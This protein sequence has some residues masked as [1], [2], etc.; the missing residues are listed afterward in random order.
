ME[1]DMGFFDETS[2]GVLISR[3][4][5]DPTFVFETYDEK[6]NT[7]VQFLAQVIVGLL[8]A[9]II[10]WRV[11]IV[12]IGV[13]P[14]CVFIYVFGEWLVDRLWKSFRDASTKTGTQA[15]EVITSFRTVKSFDNE[16]YEAEQ[17]AKNLDDVH[18]VVARAST[19]H[20][21]KN[22]AAYFF[23]FA[24]I[25]P[26]IY[27]SSYSVYLRPHLGMEIGDVITLSVCL[28][29]LL[30][31]FAMCLSVVDDM[32]KAGYSAR[33][34]LMLLEKKPERDR[35]AGEEIGSVRGKIEFCD[36]SF[37][38]K[39]RD[40]YAVEHLSFTINAGETVALV[41]ESGCGKSTTLQLLQKLYEVES[42]CIKI[43]DVDIK[44]LSD[45]SLRSQI[46][47]VPQGPVLFSMSVLDNIRFGKPDA[48]E[49]ST[50]SAARVGNAHEFIMELPE[51]YETNVVQTSLSG[52]QKQRICI[53][54]AILCDTPI[55][56]LDEATAAL[57]TESEQLVQQSLENFRHGKT[58][59][60][61]AHRLATVKHADRILVYQNGHIAESGTH[62]ELLNRSGIYSDL[63][64][65]QL[66]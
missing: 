53:S 17:Y 42:G 40:D 66:Q 19:V 26:V 3:L 13:V 21:W 5:E 6:L 8:F 47:I 30:Q 25:S 38:Y 18:S 9:L 46:S 39:S 52:G 62:E 44:D 41:G 45:V 59:I 10:S 29:N 1:Q 2:T 28:M 36:V 24:I 11:S 34:L 20:A 50:T 4:S 60:I 56:L 65:F 14:I 37:K 64:R 49:E 33:K 7:G 55:L 22:G 12:V 51:N 16:L 58:A 31:G 61:V 48:N 43:D 27:Y 63:I 23:S 15:E 54:R 57:D 35:K 32:R